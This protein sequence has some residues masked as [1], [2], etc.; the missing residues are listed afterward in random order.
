MLSPW[1]P[2][3]EVDWEA[4]YWQVEMKVSAAYVTF[5]DTT[6]ADVLD[7]SLQSL[8]G[9]EMAP[10]WTLLSQVGVG[11]RLLFVC[12]F[13]F[14]GVWWER[15][16]YYIKFSCHATLLLLWVFFFFLVHAFWCFWVVVLFS[17][18][19]EI[20]EAKRN[21]ENSLLC[22][23][24]GFGVFSQSAFLTILFSIFLSSFYM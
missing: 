9:R 18:K 2:W 17:S 20:Y 3:W 15:S 23:S 16:G 11:H 22:Y 21:P 12:L 19:S 8:N 13:I 4:C 6:P 1:T 24:L 10:T 7:T 14:C 5:S